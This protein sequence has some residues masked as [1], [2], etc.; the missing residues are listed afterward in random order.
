MEY[1]SEELELSCLLQLKELGKPDW[2]CWQVQD[3]LI[4]R[5]EFYSRR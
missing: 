1:Q 2:L 5:R 3:Q 4:V